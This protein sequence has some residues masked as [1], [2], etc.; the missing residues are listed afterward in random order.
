VLNKPNKHD[1]FYEEA[2]K[3]FEE[4]IMLKGIIEV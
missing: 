2:I 4:E 1:Q 3:A